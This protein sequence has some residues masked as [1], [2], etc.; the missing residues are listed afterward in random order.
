MLG[1]IYTSTVGVAFLVSLV[2]FRFNYEW[3]LKFFSILLGLTFFVEVLTIVMINLAHV[4]S[5]QWVYNIFIPV[6]FVCYGYFFL[7]ILKTRWIR[8]LVWALIIGCLAGGVATTFLVFHFHKWNS[9][10]AIAAA[11]FTIVFAVSY[12]YELFISDVRFELRS[13]PE[14]WIAT[15]MIIF[16]SCQL[17]FLG[18]VNY[19]V[20]TSMNLALSLLNVLRCIDI[21]MYLIFCYAFLCRIIIKRLQLS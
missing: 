7:L 3:Y 10:Q 16:Y 13:K 20:K 15:G 17:P 4:Q 9:Y 21:L 12:Y 5:T 6:E 19:L 14:F 2:S 18:T 1:Y 8:Q 11:L